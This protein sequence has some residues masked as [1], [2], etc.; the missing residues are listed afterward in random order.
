M[1][2]F[3]DA[4]VVFACTCYAAV[5]CLLVLGVAFLDDVEEG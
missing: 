1:A 3:I 2:F 4:L 5:G